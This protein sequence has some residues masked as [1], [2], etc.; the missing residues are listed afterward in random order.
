MD[1]EQQILDLIRHNPFIS[2]NE[3]AS[4]VGI[5]RSA[6]A[7]YIASL[8]KRGILRGRAYVM[9]TANSVLC[10]GGA[11]L[12]SKATSKRPI[13]SGSSNPA[14]VQES[15]GGVARNIAENLGRLACTVSL[16]TVVG[17]DQAGQWVL[18]ET[19]KLGVDTALS[20][21]LP[22]EKTGT[23]TAFLDQTG[24]MYVAFADMDIYDKFDSKLLQEKW[25]HIAASRL[26]IADANLSADG[27][28]EL[29][30]QCE[31]SSLPLF[32]DPVS[33]EKAKKLPS[34]LA[35]VTAIFPNLEE[36]IELA[37]A[38]PASFKDPD[39]AALAQAIRERGVQHVFITAGERGVFY[40]GD[41][42]SA[43]IPPIPTEVVEVTGA[44]DAFVA[45]VA[46]GILQ[47]LPYMEACRF[48]I[49]AS[50]LTLQTAESV[51]ADLNEP[52]LQQTAKE[53][54]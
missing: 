53:R 17:D 48:G 15:C 27:L 34:N 19:A 54:F 18:K 41:E 26:V 28:G 45:G 2:Q 4:S 30:K 49:A 40:S 10:I 20:Q 35:G 44:G 1:R 36:A 29:V 12:D 51:S 7:G 13:R 39:F 24:E 11:N 50:H 5:S 14:N 9:A 46:Y 16:L 47:D 42:G 23:Y 31:A 25:P 37:G 43:L 8:T 3:I 6:V 33:S 22:Q 21:V 52:T 38:D 32:V